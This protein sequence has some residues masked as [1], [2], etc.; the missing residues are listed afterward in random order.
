MLD[1]DKIETISKSVDDHLRKLEA[2]TG[3]IR[4]VKVA[5]DEI[6]HAKERDYMYELQAL[7]VVVSDLVEQLGKRGLPQADKYEKD[8]QDLRNSLNTPNWPIAVEPEAICHTDESAMFRAES[9]LDLLVGEHM[10]DKKFLD[11]GCGEGHVVLKAKDR[12]VKLALGYDVDISK[13]KTPSAEFT[14]NFDVVKSKA[15]FDIILLHDVL[16]HAVIL[17]PLEILLQAKSV[18]SPKGRIYVR[19]HPWSSRHGG[20]LYTKMNKAFLHLAFDAVELSRIGG[21]QCEP[22]VRVMT[23]LETYRHWFAETGFKVV[24]EIPI[25]NPVEPFFLLP[26]PLNDRIKKKF[27]DPHAMVNHMEISMVEYVLEP[28]GLN[29][30][31]V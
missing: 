28:V 24:S 6:R 8:L 1:L 20:H 7:R 16:D 26:S 21:Y 9:I 11:F 4:E 30:Q 22:N 13:I 31:I 3:S 2:L 18:L 15:P 14:D 19:N 27:Q 12:E 17:N 25:K 5:L 10:K 23:P 29:H